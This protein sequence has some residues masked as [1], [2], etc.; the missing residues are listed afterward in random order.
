[1]HSV[2]VHLKTK[3]AITSTSALT[4]TIR[5]IRHLVKKWYIYLPRFRVLGIALVFSMANS[6]SV[7]EG[8]AGLLAREGRKTLSASESAS[9]SLPDVTFSGPDV[10]VRIVVYMFNLNILTERSGVNGFFGYENVLSYISF[11]LNLR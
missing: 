8:E 1:M 7:L 9:P 4:C 10:S 2:T 11:S 5:N 6:V 3:W